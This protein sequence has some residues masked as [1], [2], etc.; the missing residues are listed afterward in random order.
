MAFISGGL[1]NAAEAVEVVEALLRRLPGAF[2]NLLDGLFI[3][4]SRLPADLCQF[5]KLHAAFFFQKAECI[6]GGNTIVL[7]IVARQDKPVPITFRQ[8]SEAPH[9][10]CG[11]ETGCV[12]PENLAF[13]FLLKLFVFQEHFECLGVLESLLRQYISRGL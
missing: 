9:V 3:P 5:C 4:R 2:S 8:I 13:R 1:D 11:N 10:L 7:S 12:N 6:T